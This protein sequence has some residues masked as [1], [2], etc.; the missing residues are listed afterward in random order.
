M[1]RL[2]KSMELFAAERNG[3]PA[4][5]PS[6]RPG[7]DGERRTAGRCGNLCRARQ[8]DDDGN[9]RRGRL[10]VRVG[11]GPRR[12]R[13]TREGVPRVDAGRHGADRRWCRGCP[14]W[15]PT[16]TRTARWPTRS[17]STISTRFRARPRNRRRPFLLPGAASGFNESARATALIADQKRLLGDAGEKTAKETAAA[18]ELKSR[19]RTRDGA[20]LAATLTRA[21]KAKH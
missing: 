17:C 1:R 3:G 12:G 5:D 18:I 10:V 14:A 8:A 19:I 4:I 9:P 13:G 15:S 21:T 11:A 2:R 16:T 7:G 6:L 20:S